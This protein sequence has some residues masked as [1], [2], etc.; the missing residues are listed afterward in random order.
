MFIG[1][2]KT[3]NIYQEQQASFCMLFEHTHNWGYTSDFLVEN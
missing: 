1:A 2:L 3:S